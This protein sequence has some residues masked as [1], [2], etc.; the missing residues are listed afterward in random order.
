MI[1]NTK[2][3]KIYLEKI[4]E[5]S[6]YFYLGVQIIYKMLSIEIKRLFSEMTQL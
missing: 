6:N 1:W 4:E 3:N 2:E 5:K